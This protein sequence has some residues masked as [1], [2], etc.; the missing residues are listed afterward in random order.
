MAP[1]AK[2]V[3]GS[4]QSRKGE[5][6]GSSSGREPVQKFGKKVVERYGWEWFKCQRE[7]K[8]MGDEFVNKGMPINVGAILRQSMMKFRNNMRWRFCYGGLITHFL[9]REGIEEETVDITVAYHPNLTG[10]LVDVTRIGT[11]HVPWTYLV[12]SREASRDDSFMARMFGIAELQLW[13][14]GVRSG[15]TFLE[16]LDDDEATTDEA[17]DDEE[18][19]AVNEETNALKVFN[20]GDDEA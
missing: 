14:G 1:K 18:D 4:K 20:G 16:P 19:D 15:P 10:K 5:A 2:N 12:C 6:F 9:R 11:R 7:V 17:M 13:I 8:Y 3:E